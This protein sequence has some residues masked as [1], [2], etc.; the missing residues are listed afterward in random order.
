MNETKIIELVLDKSNCSLS[1]VLNIWL[2]LALIIIVLLSKWLIKKY[3]KGGKVHKD[4]VP[5]KLKYSVGG[6]EIEYE[7][8]RNYQNIEIAHKI[9]I[10][11]VTRKAAIKIDQEKDVIVEVYNSWYTLFQVTRDELKKIPGKMLLE[12]N[13]SESLIALLSDILNKGLRPHLTEYQA[14]FRKWYNSE[15][16]KDENKTLSPQQIQSKCDYYKELIIS[17]SEV[18]RLLIDYS[19]QLEIIIRGK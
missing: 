8:T 16:E 14:K 1:L 3:L 11:L 18:N 12:N 19:K 17:M 7:I 5:I 10:E 4:I 15:L 9:Y 6:A 13:T 2:L